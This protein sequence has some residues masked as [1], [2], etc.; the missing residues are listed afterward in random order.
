A[1]RIDVADKR[2][3]ARPPL[4]GPRRRRRRSPPVIPLLL[5]WLRAIGLSGQAVAVGGAALAIAVLMLSPRRSTGSAAESRPPARA[6]DFTL[7]LAA[8]GAAIAA[9]AQVGVLALLTMDLSGPAGWPVAAVLESTVGVSGLCRI[10]AGILTGSAAIA[11]R[12]APR[13]I[14][15]RGIL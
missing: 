7:A 4:A 13:S 10:G 12:R 1:L 8:L 11:L 15:R 5:V 14:L 2:R 9:A 6:A 3:G